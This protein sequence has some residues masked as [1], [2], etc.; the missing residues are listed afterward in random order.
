MQV[1]LSNQPLSQDSSV[2]FST[3]RGDVSGSTW[4]SG[5]DLTARGGLCVENKVGVGES[6]K[7]GGRIG[8]REGVR[9]RAGVG[10]RAGGWVDGATICQSG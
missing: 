8:G 6:S 9:E 5:N 4:E 10:E 7:K 3:D 2:E 1:H